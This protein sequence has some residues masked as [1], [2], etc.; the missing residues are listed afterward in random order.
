MDRTEL[1][2]MV[3]MV[4]GKQ[5]KDKTVK[6]FLNKLDKDGSG[7]VSLQEWYDMNRRCQSLL[8]P[9]WDLQRKLRHRVLGVVYWE[10]ATR[11]RLN[12]V[13]KHDLI[14]L[15]H[16]LDTGEKLDRK[17]IEE[18]AVVQKEGKVMANLV[19]GIDV[20]N[21]PN[22]TADVVRTLRANASIIV[23]EERPDED[24]NNP[25]MWYLIAPDKH[26]WVPAEFIKLDATWLKYEAELEMKKQRQKNEVEK[27][28]QAEIERQKQLKE[29]HCLWSEARDPK[30]KRKYWYNSQT[31]ETTWKSPFKA[32]EKRSVSI[33]SKG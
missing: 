17:K 6:A 22:Q 8:M 16:Y 7:E 1:L 29:L 30:T 18:N 10:R 9:A 21:N 28:R 3:Y 2:D 13:G 20:R 24:S 32:F 26:E 23:Y 31:N 4:L 11:K 19:S 33:M 25:N 15:F 12:R 27:K 5:S 14:E